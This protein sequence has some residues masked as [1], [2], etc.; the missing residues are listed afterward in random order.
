MW[1]KRGSS[2]FQTPKK[3]PKKHNH[4]FIV[5][6]TDVGIIY[7]LCTSKLCDKI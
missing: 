7:Q 2:I 1:E 3:T 6:L 4:N 5:F